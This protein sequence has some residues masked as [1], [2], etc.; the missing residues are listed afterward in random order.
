MK[1][2][3]VLLVLL[4]SSAAAAGDTVGRIRERHRLVV[5]HRE[6]SIPFS[7]LDARGKPVGYAI[8]ICMKVAD[9]IRRELR[10][11]TLDIDYLPVTPE[12]RMAAIIEGRADLECGS[13]TNT[14]ERRRDV[15]FSIPYFVAAA[16]VLVRTDS[17]IRNW[18]DLRGR[19]VVTTKGTTNARTLADRDK[20]RSLNI[21]LVEGKDHAE[22][23][24]MVERN[25]ADAFAMDDI[26]LYGLRASAK[27]PADFSIVGDALSVEPYAVMVGKLDPAFKRIVDREIARLMMDGELYAIYDKWFTRPIPPQG[28]NLNM[29]MSHLL[30]N[31]I[32]YPGDRF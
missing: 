20:V 27:Q 26:L 7:Y 21:S 11:P 6:S 19:R 25:E 23:F 24:A 28:I 18:T 4:L 17:G 31:V 16:R 1:A 30:R 8:D 15:D 3:A 29:P 9:A 12:T 13:T 22:G 14:A 10:L 32:R 5:A 2:V